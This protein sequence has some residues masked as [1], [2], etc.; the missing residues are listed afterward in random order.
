MNTEISP[1]RNR[2]QNLQ[3]YRPTRRPRFSVS[4]NDNSYQLRVEL[5]GVSR[6]G[7]ELTLEN[8]ILKLVAR[9]IDFEA[10]EWEVLS[11]QSV[12]G[13]YS[14]EWQLG[15]AIDEDS[16]EASVQ[17]GVLRLNLSKAD[18]AKRRSIEVN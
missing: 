8:Q 6:E 11:R 4:E 7:V 1:E 5:P 14:H 13:D 2:D 10:K 17:D 15:S 3:T 18:K 12:P 16:I 9:R